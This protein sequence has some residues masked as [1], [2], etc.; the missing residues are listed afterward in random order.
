LTDG[1]VASEKYFTTKGYK[2]ER[3]KYLTKQ[4]SYSDKGRTEKA[5]DPYGYSIRL[6]SEKYFDPYGNF[7]DQDRWG[8]KREAAPLPQRPADVSEQ[9]WSRAKSF[10]H[11]EQI[12][13]YGRVITETQK[14]LSKQ[15]LSRARSLTEKAQ[16]DEF[17]RVIYKRKPPTKKTQGEYYTFLTPMK[18]KKTRILFLSNT[19]LFS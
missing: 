4:I 13:R 17:G 12:K 19:K 3:Q 5:F 15:Q 2:G 6:R 11:E 1:K 9:E 7:L 18:I 10:T 14:P 16:E 8:I